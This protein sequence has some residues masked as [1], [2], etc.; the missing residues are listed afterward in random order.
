MTFEKAL[1]SDKIHATGNWKSIFMKHPLLHLLFV[2]LL[3]GLVTPSTAWAQVQTAPLTVVSSSQPSQTTAYH[4]VLPLA[5]A[6]EAA[7]EG[8]RVCAQHGYFV[9]ATVVDMDG[10][11][12]VSLRGDGAT[13]HTAESSFDKAYTVV[14]LGP[15]FDFDTSGKFFDLVRTSPYAPRLASMTNVMAL[16]GAVAFKSKNRIVGALGV[17]GAPGGDK[18]EVCA[19]AGVAKV[20][21]R[22]P[23]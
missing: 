13:I 18:D 12:Q 3:A 6:L 16:P 22:L 17:G 20:A 5:L 19:Q 21:D 8:V 7:T 14:T 11:P 10:K 9:T 23:N 2:S 4:Y 15:I 1:R